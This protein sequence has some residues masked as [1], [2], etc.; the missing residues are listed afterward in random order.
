MY[1]SHLWTLI[2]SGHPCPC[3]SQ[4]C[5]SAVCLPESSVVRSTCCSCRRP[6]FTSQ[7]LH[8]TIVPDWLLQCG[9]GCTPSPLPLTQCKAQVWSDRLP[10]NCLPLVFLEWSQAPSFFWSHALS[11]FLTI[12]HSDVLSLMSGIS[13]DWFSWLPHTTAQGWK[14]WGPLFRMEFLS[15][16]R[17][18]RL[19]VR[20]PVLNPVTTSVQSTVQPSLLARHG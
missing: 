9:S 10:S 7:H 20:P 1:A 16:L 17:T 13:G 2:L 18:H 11:D 3:H 4:A 14:G 19:P 5:C 12:V 6:R 8:G 15:R